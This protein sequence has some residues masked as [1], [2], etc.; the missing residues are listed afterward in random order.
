[1]YAAH[2]QETL[3]G[4]GPRAT[5]TITGGDVFSLGATGH[6]VC[7]DAATG[8]EKW[9][10]DILKDNNP[11]IQWGMS[12]SPLVYDDFVV[13]NPGAQKDAARGRA[14]VAYDRKTGKE[15]W[16]SGNSPAGYSS[17][18]LATLAGKRQVLLL[19]GTGFSG[20]DAATGRELWQFPWQTYQNIN[21]AQP[22]VIDA[23]RVFIS[24]GYNHGCALLK[25]VEKDGQWMV[26]QVWFNGKGLRCKFTS[27]VLYQGHLYGLDEGVLA[28][29]EVETGKQ[30]WRDGRYGH[31][32]LLLSGDLLV[33]TGEQGKLALVQATPE[34][35]TE[36]GRIQ[37]LEDAKTW[38]L[39]AMQDGKV[40][41]RNE[42]EMACYDLAAGV[43][44][45]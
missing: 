17:P 16:T 30:K 34:K 10:V 1:V 18:M 37:A 15:V 21:V 39:P 3:G 23:D 14:V 13:V 22:V 38:N 2:F 20:F 5:P 19:D 31:G 8:K 11:N 42:Q 12:G 6:L 43:E 41:V 26:T 25:F 29:I 33:V 28:C 7:L 32:Q 24:A 35:F 40:F 36:L 45:K 9:A 4:P 44:K 27:P